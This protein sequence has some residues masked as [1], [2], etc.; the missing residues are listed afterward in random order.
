MQASAV[1]FDGRRELLEYEL[2]R[3]RLEILAKRNV[4]YAK[5]G[6]SSLLLAI[7]TCDIHRPYNIAGYSINYD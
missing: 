6:Y 4:S 7:G 3:E 2:L 1:R 5:V